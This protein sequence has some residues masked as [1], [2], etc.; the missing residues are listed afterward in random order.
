MLFLFLLKP[1]LILVNYTELKQTTTL[2]A[3]SDHF[4][5]SR[6]WRVIGDQVQTNHHGRPMML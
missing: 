5:L 1:L 6:G 3:L 4:I 2:L